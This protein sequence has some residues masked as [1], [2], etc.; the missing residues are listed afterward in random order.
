MYLQPVVKVF[1]YDH[2]VSDRLLLYQNWVAH[3]RRASVFAPRVGF[4]APN[5]HVRNHTV[6]DLDVS[7]QSGT[8]SGASTIV[9]VFLQRDIPY[10]LLIL[11]VPGGDLNPHGLAAC[12][13]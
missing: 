9:D 4:S 2:Q 1:I 10:K 11:L 5:R 13:F 6:R 12:G 7:V 3:P 8:I